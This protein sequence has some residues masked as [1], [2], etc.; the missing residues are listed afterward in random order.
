[1]DKSIRNKLF[2][3]MI[4][5]IAVWGAWL[6]LIFGY[7]PS[8]GFNASEQSWILNAFAAGAIV[9]MFFSNQFA[10]RKFAAEKFMAFSHLLGGAAILALG[11]IQPDAGVSAESLAAAAAAKDGSVGAS[12]IF[13]PFF[14]LMLVHCL[15]YVPTLSIANSIAFTHLKDAKKDYGF[16]RM[17]GTLGW[18]LVAWPFVF[19]LVDWAKVPAMG[20]VGMVE[21]LGKVF[22]TSKTGADFQAGVRATYI[23]SG[24]ISLV[25]AGFSLTLPHTPPKPGQGQQFAWLE[26]FSL[27]KKPAIFIL[28][29]VTFMDAF[30]HNL[31]FAWTGSF[32]GAKPESGGVGIA[33]NWIMPVMTIGQVAE[34]LTMAVLGLVLKKLGWRWTMIIGILGHA[35]RFGA[36][37]LFHDSQ[38]M[39]IAVQ[40][41][42]GICYAFFFA[43]LYIF[44]DEQFP[45][46]IRTSA[47]GLFNMLVFGL[48][49][50]ASFYFGPMLRDGYTKGTGETA[51][52][53]WD[54][55]FI[56]PCGVA[57]AAA[58]I[59][60]VLFH[61]PKEEPSVAGGGAAPH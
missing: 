54:K 46:D 15:L 49:P 30:V 37:V 2:V 16:V 35:A 32:L 58:V 42:H 50:L 8:L 10:D 31:Y 55:L 20:D 3:M 34:L 5:E 39:I 47:Q 23:V 27:L 38:G 59:L 26:A 21:W 60:A 6:P 4:L 61:P 29:V 53:A 52:V 14:G 36:Y 24:I 44:I 41:L 25:L 9:A 43:T 40:I 45:K 1:M 51:V 13:W 7:L 11:F 22:G 33:G 12:P 28:F 19:I 56:I 18:I 57:L 48:G 17:G